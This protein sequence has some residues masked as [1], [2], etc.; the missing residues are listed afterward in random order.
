MVETLKMNHLFNHFSLPDSE[1]IYFPSLNLQS[2]MLTIIIVTLIYRW[3][4][5]RFFRNTQ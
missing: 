1:S 4:I 3:V 5:T 2:I